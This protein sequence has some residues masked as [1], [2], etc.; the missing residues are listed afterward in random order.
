MKSNDSSS[1][2]W[3]SMRQLRM[4]V[5][6]I[7]LFSTVFLSCQNGK[8][9]DQNTLD[10][11]SIP[12][13][14]M[15]PMSI[16]VPVTFV[17]DIQAVQFVE[18]RAKVEGYVDQIYV[19]EGQFV[20]KGQN[21]FQLSSM[22]FLEMVNSANAKLAQAKA[23]AQAAQVEVDRL[24]I[25]VEKDIISPSELQLARS[26]KA[27]AESGI[28]EAESMLKNAKTGLSYTTIK[29]PF[30][31]IVDRIPYKK[32]SLIPQGELLTNIT[33]ISEVFA[34]FKITENE[35]LRYMR[36]KMEGEQGD[37]GENV[38]LILADGET[39]QYPGKLETMEADFE[40]GT[41]SI[42]LRVRF[43]NPD[44]LIKHGSTGRIQMN[45]QLNNVFLVPQKST[46]E[47]QDYSYVYIL[48]KNNTVK[49]RSF[50][51]VRRFGLFYVA[52]GF[53]IGDRIIYEGIQQVKDG[54]VILPNLISQK[55]AYDTLSISL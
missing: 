49:V 30:D 27:V 18:V 42:A 31:G 37:I 35:Y 21:L 4:S 29:A 13:L 11:Q 41:G 16:E 22:E 17:A 53:E 44:Q 38:K 20:R 19:D 12:I 24:K 25:L 23:E 26:K 51:P 36:A 32:G 50:K 14:E 48:D 7:L 9:K 33:D 3:K 39:Y 2:F 46:F 8:T 45:N 43:T 6:S 54:M 55:E 47:I 10:L 34:Y 28:L 52:E 5:L 15:K 1:S 40:R